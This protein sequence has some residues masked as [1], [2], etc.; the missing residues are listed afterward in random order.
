MENDDST[1]MLVS[2]ISFITLFVLIESPCD[3]TDLLSSIHEF[4]TREVKLLSVTHTERLSDSLE[5]RI[6]SAG[7]GFTRHRV[8]EVMR[9]Q[10]SIYVYNLQIVIYFP[11]F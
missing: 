1:P 3:D 8:S 11:I 2:L 9:E 6:G 5:K 10:N 7:V 4:S